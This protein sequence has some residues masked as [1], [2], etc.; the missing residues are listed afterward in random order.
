[1][2]ARRDG[3]VDPGDS[4]P[5]SRWRAKNTIDA[6][7]VASTPCGNVLAV[8]R[9]TV[10]FDVACGISDER[11][12]IRGAQRFGNARMR[13]LLVCVAKPLRRTRRGLVLG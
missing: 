3:L 9:L 2:R 8:L 13:Q 10:Q 1:M 6:R 5:R 7:S 4:S 12:G 11:S